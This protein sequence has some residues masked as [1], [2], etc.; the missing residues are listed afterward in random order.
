MEYNYVVQLSDLE[1]VQGVAPQEN[2]HYYTFDIFS[3]EGAADPE[4]IKL[5]AG[6]YTLGVSGET[7]AGTFTRRVEERS[8][9]KAERL[10]YRTTETTLSLMPPLSMMRVIRT[11]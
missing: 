10:S 2:G 7:A 5:P 8:C 6:T 9:S 4:N 11:M 1:L 3:N